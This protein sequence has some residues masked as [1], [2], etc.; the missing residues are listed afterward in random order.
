MP[1][2]SIEKA[3]ELQE[4]VEA[5]RG[6]EAGDQVDRGKSDRKV[7]S[8]NAL[9]LKDRGGGQKAQEGE[10][11]VQMKDTL[12]SKG[13]VDAQTTQ[14]GE[15]RVESETAVEV[16]G[17]KE[18]KK[19]LQVERKADTKKKEPLSA[20]ETR[21]GIEIEYSSEAEDW[22][23]DDEEY[24]SGLYLTT[25]DE[26]EVFLTQRT[27]NHIV[28]LREEKKSSLQAIAEYFRKDGKVLCL[29]GS[30][31]NEVAFKN[32]DKEREEVYDAF[33][34]ATSFLKSSTY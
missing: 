22:S 25:L 16:K 31:S 13:G 26:Y 33:V 2:I 10:K 15:R 23:E 1:T 14:E 29:S 8:G 24:E 5:Q 3:T 27:L 11:Q 7:E 18:E 9:E 17:S 6:R 21:G 12:D 34:K 30:R 32:L 4:N 19:A 20:M 28:K